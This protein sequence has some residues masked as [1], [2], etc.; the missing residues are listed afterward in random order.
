MFFRFLVCVAKNFTEFQESLLIVEI[1][2]RLPN[3]IN[4]GNDGPLI[5]R[6][7]EVGAVL[8]IVT[9]SYFFVIIIIIA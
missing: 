2:A 4:L 3:G 9:T 7:G 1:L 6:R 5:S 8:L